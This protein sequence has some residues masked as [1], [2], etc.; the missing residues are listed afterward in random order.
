MYSIKH[1]NRLR[2]KPSQKNKRKI[3]DDE[4]DYLEW[5]QC[6]NS[7]CMVCNSGHIEYHHVKKNSTDKKDHKRLIPLCIEHHKG[8][9]LSPH[10]TPKL[11]KEVFSIE[12]QQEVADAMYN[13]YLKEKGV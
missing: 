10:G 12:Y 13:E 9:E 2:P 3:T 11:F 8:T 7:G 6:R 5:L 4:Q 1:H